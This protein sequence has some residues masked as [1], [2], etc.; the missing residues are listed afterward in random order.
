LPGIEED[1]EV[2]ALAEAALAKAGVAGEVPTPLDRVAEAAG[3]VRTV[4]VSQL[5][6]KVRRQPPRVLSRIL[7]AYFFNSDTAFVDSSLTPGRRRFVY[8]HEVA[9]RLIPWHARAF[10]LDDDRRLFG[11][12][13]EILEAEANVAA[14]HLLFQGHRFFERAA[15]LPPGVKGAVRLARQHGA[16]YHAT[17][18]YYVRHNPAPMA[19]LVA[20][21]VRRKDGSIPLWEAVVSPSFED[22]VAP[23]AELSACDRLGPGADNPI[24]GLCEAVD[25]GLLSSAVLEGAGHWRTGSGWRP[26]RIETMQQR[27]LFVLVSA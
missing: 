13:E 27:S 26:V 18:R 19:L 1:G 17:L 25:R 16:S 23:A 12:T 20:G 15:A 6:A 14:S 4:D 11:D 22:R 9:H 5:P 24:E 2:Q 10:C 3:V 7:G 21:R 8:A